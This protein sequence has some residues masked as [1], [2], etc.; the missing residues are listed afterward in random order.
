MNIKSILAVIFVYLIAVGGWAILGTAMDMRSDTSM[1]G[2]DQ[3]VRSLWGAPI[4][5]SGP[6]FTYQS[7]D[8][9]FSSIL[10]PLQTRINVDIALEH[11]RKGLIWY[12]TFTSVFDSSFVIENGHE[13][14][15][16]VHFS[17]PFPV[18]DGTYDAFLVQQ[19]KNTLD[20]PIDVQKGVIYDFQLQPGQK[21]IITLQYTT[22]GIHSWSYQINK[23]IGRVKDFSLV[24]SCDFKNYDYQGGSMSADGVKISDNGVDLTWITKDR[25]TQQYI[26]VDMPSKVNPGPLAAR[27]TYFA[28]VCLIFFFALLAA[29]ST[30]RQIEIHP[31]HYFFVACGFFAFHLL[32]AYMVDLLNVHISFLISTA[33]T[34][35]LVTSYLRTALKGAFPVVIS[36][37]GQLFFLVLFSY[38][39]F[40]NGTTGL[41]VAIGSVLTLAVMMHLT[42][43]INWKN[44]FKPIRVRQEIDS[45][46]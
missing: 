15:I 25:I 27:M 4:I 31:M 39:F 45:N 35:L 12:P 38:S 8:K 20:L 42:A 14:A 7:Q 17:M 2:L 40:L 11:R 1:C 5:Q 22:R 30:V 29:I 33:T 36:I 16:P 18:A 46:E 23:E 9:S 3:E 13:H 34:L 26:G 32:F 24:M 41:V 21:T 37:G 6:S 43:H 44:Y 28:P 10:I 19:D